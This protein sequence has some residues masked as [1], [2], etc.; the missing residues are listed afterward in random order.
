MAVYLSEYIKILHVE[1]F[2]RLW[3]FRRWKQ[4]DTKETVLVNNFSERLPGEAAERAVNVKYILF[5]YFGQKSGG[6]FYSM[7]LH[8]CQCCSS[9]FFLTTPTGNCYKIA[10]IL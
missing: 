7:L 10:G 4:M 2:D 6:T 8:S 1:R 3:Y 9:L 5:L